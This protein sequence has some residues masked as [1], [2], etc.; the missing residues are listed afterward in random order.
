MKKLHLLAAVLMIVASLAACQKSNQVNSDAQSSIEEELPTEDSMSIKTDIEAKVYGTASDKDLFGKCLVSRL[1]NRVAAFDDKTTKMCVVIGEAITTNQLSVQDYLEI[2]RCKEN[3]GI[4]L[5]TAVP[6]D[7]YS[8]KFEVEMALA[9]YYYTVER[10][11]ITIDDQVPEVPKTYLDFE[12]DDVSA[13][14]AADGVLYDCAG[15]GGLKDCYICQDIDDT[16]YDEDGNIIDYTPT[17]YDYG[18]YADAAVQWAEDAVRKSQTKAGESELTDALGAWTKTFTRPIYTWSLG[19]NKKKTYSNAVSEIISVYPAHSIPDK[20][21]FYYIT[22]DIT[23][24]TGR[25]GPVPIPNNPKQWWVAHYDCDGNEYKGLYIQCFKKWTSTLTLTLDGC[26][27]RARSSSPQAENS[28]TNYSQSTTDGVSSSETHGL[29]IG[30]SIGL[31]PSYNPSYSYSM[32]SG[33]SH[34]VTVGVSRNKSD[35]TIRK[36]TDTDN[37]VRWEYEGND[38][39]WYCTNGDTGDI[40]WR[41]GD[42]LIS[43][44]TQT[45]AVLFEVPNATTGRA[46]LKVANKY[47]FRS[48]YGKSDVS[49]GTGYELGYVDKYFSDSDVFKIPTPYRSTQHWVFSI[50]SYGNI[51]GDAALCLTVQNMIYDK[52]FDGKPAVEAID[53]NDSSTEYAKTAMNA[54]IDD[55][56]AFELPSGINGEFKFKMTRKGDGKVI[57]AKCKK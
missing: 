15:F 52:F 54:F 3:G 21:D 53:L 48:A 57:T 44:M 13:E 31:C 26:N 25:I 2:Y 40:C 35:I 43:D 8:L 7:D 51:D 55:F 27:P 46:K 42:L 20:K 1:S 34:S 22:Q 12:L 23:F 5:V 38:P 39:D 28:S 45:N 16:G 32:T 36:Y 30:G 19:F 11:G 17:A 33:T 47:G 41:V 10:N 4:V 37:S 50:S 6:A 29:T 56:S 49:W 18:C 14:Q 9:E 24:Y